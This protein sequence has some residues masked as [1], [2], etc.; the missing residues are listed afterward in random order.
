MSGDTFPEFS[1]LHCDPVLIVTEKRQWRDAN[2]MA[3]D[4]PIVDSP[5]AFND[6]YRW[7]IQHPFTRWKRYTLK[8]EPERSFQPQTASA[9]LID[10]VP[11]LARHGL[12]LGQLQAGLRAGVGSRPVRLERSAATAIADQLRQAPIQL[13]GPALRQIRLRHPELASNHRGAAR[14]SPGSPAR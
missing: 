7:H 5:E 10:I 13:Q 11:L 9:E 1:R 8:A 14:P 6:H 4:D 2:A 3:R 12:P